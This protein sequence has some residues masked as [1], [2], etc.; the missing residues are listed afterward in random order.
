MTETLKEIKRSAETDLNTHKNPETL[1]AL[2][3]AKNA[4]SKA[5]RVSKQGRDSDGDGNEDEEDAKM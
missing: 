4:A 2:K 5:T 3:K 1:D